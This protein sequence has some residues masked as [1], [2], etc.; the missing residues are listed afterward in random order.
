MREELRQ[1]WHVPGLETHYTAAATLTVDGTLNLETPEAKVQFMSMGDC[2]GEGDAVVYLPFAHVLFAGDI[3]AP[4][5]VPY[6]KGRTPTIRAWIKAL[7]K[8]DALDIDTV[9][10][11]HGELA[12]KEAITHQREF[13]EALLSSAEAAIKSGQT[14]DQAAQSIKLDT[15]AAWEH[16]NDWLGE[17]VKLVYRELQGE[18][19]GETAPVGAGIVQ[20]KAVER[21][22]AFRDK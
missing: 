21:S 13:L 20:P 15:F 1:L 8:L 6:Y 3:V 14:A 5:Y 11:G 2:V 7:K 22:D 9:V 19:A 16:Y 4:N 12:R 17:N 10:P 18:P